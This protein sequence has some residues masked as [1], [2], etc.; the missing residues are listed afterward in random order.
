MSKEFW[1]GYETEPMGGG[2][3]YYCCVGCK[4]T[5][6]EI[7]GDIDKH[8]TGCTEVE[9]YRAEQAKSTKLYAVFSNHQ[10]TDGDYEQLEFTSYDLDYVREYV[11]E[12][13]KRNPDFY[14]Y[15]DVEV[16]GS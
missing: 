3:P 14:H 12:K 4:R 10:C 11:A 16:R 8:G 2:N 15:D 6:P 1:A 13:N 7:N 9:K 5:D